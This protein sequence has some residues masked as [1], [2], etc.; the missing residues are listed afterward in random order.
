MKKIIK[1]GFLILLIGL[2]IGVYVNY[3]RLNIISG[4]A[5][6]NMASS[7]FLAHR[8]ESSVAEFDNNFDPIS[9]A[10]TRVNTLNKS[11]SSNSFG[12]LE[13]TAFY[14]EGL[15]AV[16]VDDDFDMAAPYLKPLRNKTAKQLPYPYGVL[17]QKDTV[18]ANVDY[19]KIQQVVN[20]AFDATGERIQKTRSVLV[21]YK[22]QI[23]AEK[24]EDGIDKKTPILGWSM[25]K[26]ITST[27]IG[28]LTKQQNFDIYK[29]A[30]ILKWNEDERSKI[31][32]HNL[33]QMNSGLEWVEDYN[34]ISDVSKMLFLSRD[35]TIVQRDKKQ[36]FAPGTHWN[37]S[38]GTSNLLSRIIRG[39][40]KTHQEYLDYWYTELIDRIGMHSMTIETDMAG[41]YVGSSYGWATTRDWAKFGLLYLHKGDWNG[42][43]VFDPSWE[44]YVKT[45][46]PNSDKAYGGHFWLNA[47]NGYKDVP[48]TM[49]SCNGYQGQRISIFPSKD[50][51]IVRM[52]LANGDVFDFNALLGGVYAAIE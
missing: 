2:V 38:S 3:P 12:I 24:Y 49:Y 45:P 48:E 18:F 17:A 34:T 8:T 14:R 40:F 36:D 39:Q 22:D 25:T 5:S 28:I 23:I 43:K 35:M 21:I 6:K 19:Q 32:T 15:G 27:I 29:P 37:Y 26:S 10:E 20:A 11:V 50:L 16:L 9:K 44:N 30:P 41:N 31:T 46:A 33:L 51:V 47:D 13:R 7:V 52:G 1:Y 42:T 4:Y